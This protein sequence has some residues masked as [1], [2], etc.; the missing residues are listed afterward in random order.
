MHHALDAHS[1]AVIA[2]EDQMFL[3]WLLHG[4]TS[5]VAQFRSGKE[6]PAADFGVFRQMFDAGGNSAQYRWASSQPAS[7]WYQ[8]A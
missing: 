5:Q 3:K 7:R 8:A 4:P 1:R 6:R 2:V